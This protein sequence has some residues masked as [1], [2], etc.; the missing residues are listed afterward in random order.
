MLLHV[1]LPARQFIILEFVFDRNNC[2]SHFMILV[3]SIGYVYYWLAL[4]LVDS[5]IR[6]I[7][8][9]DSFVCQPFR[10]AV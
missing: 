3:H 10:A 4:S 2:I 7:M 8:Y 5:T 1:V 6:L 9:R